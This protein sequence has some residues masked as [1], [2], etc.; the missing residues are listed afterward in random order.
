MVAARP[1]N[2]SYEALRSGVTRRHQGLMGG[3]IL[4]IPY[5]ILSPTSPTLGVE[6]IQDTNRD[7][8]VGDR[9]KTIVSLDM[10]P[11]ANATKIIAQQLPQLQ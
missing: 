5:T 2:H 8:S 9:R 10:L 7:N 6:L 4:Q 11:V 3:E 1:F